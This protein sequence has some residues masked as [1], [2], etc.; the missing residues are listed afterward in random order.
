MHVHI[1]THTAFLKQAAYPHRHKAR[2]ATRVSRSHCLS[3]QSPELRQRDIYLELRGPVRL[4]LSNP[5]GLQIWRA[6]LELPSP[7]GLHTKL[8][9]KMKREPEKKQ[10]CKIWKTRYGRVCECLCARFQNCNSAQRVC[11]YGEQD[12]KKLGAFL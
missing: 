8:D 11:K 5:A 9:S 6:R 7:A 2:C 12:C 3:S 10:D 1:H 4:K